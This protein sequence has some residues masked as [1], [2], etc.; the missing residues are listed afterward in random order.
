[1]TNRIDFSDIIPLLLAKREPAQQGYELALAEFERVKNLLEVAKNDLDRIDDMLGQCG[2]V[3]TAPVAEIET[4]EE[5]AEE[6]SDFN[7]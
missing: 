3:E 2:Y 4:V 1:M 5:V 6:V 7:N